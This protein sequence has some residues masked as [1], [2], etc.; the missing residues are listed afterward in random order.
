MEG[1][2]G[3]IGGFPGRIYCLAVVPFP[4]VKGQHSHWECGCAHSS[5][6]LRGP[7]YFIA[8]QDPAANPIQLEIIWSWTIVLVSGICDTDL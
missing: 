1:A 8:P 5:G 2:A 7:Y 3:R 6:R 4:N